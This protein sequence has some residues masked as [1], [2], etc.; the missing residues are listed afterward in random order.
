M[1]VDA[2]T[3]RWEQLDQLGSEAAERIR[4]LSDGPVAQPDTT[5]TAFKAAMAP[6]DVAILHGLVS[7]RT[8][9]SITPE[10]VAEYVREQKG[11]PTPCVG[12]AGI[13]PL[14]TSAKAAIAS[15]REHNLAGITIS[16]A[17]GGFHPSHS[18]AMALYEAAEAESLPVC[19]LTDSGRSAS[20]ELAFAQ[21]AL[22]DEVARSFPDLKLL[23]G[24]AGDPFTDQALLILSKHPNVYA[25]VADVI[26][27]PW[28]LYQLLV[29]AYQRGVIDRLAFGSGFPFG[30]PEQAITDLYSVNGLSKGSDMPAVPR[31]QLRGIV[32]RDLLS[33]LGIDRPALPASEASAAENDD[34]GHADRQLDRE[35]DAAAAE[36]EEK[37]A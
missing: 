2:Q 25:T 4:A 12:F 20:A 5:T 22:L 7:K 37:N 18:R 35:A 16:P 29:S 15:C 21:P 14:A 6:V 27:R 33:A 8:G 36:M 10:Q 1:I 23:I 13:D 9:A 32:E 19:L 28:Q 24:G 11:S 34:N 26:S 30:D 31:E 3:F 17:E